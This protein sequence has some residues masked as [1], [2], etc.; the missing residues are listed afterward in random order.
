MRQFIYQQELIDLPILYL[1][2]LYMLNL[3]KDLNTDERV[4]RSK[5]TS[6]R[7]KFF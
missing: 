5:F 2:T 4:T 6:I 1:N 3:I 7:K